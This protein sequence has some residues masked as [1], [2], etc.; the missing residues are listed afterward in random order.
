MDIDGYNGATLLVEVVIGA[1]AWMILDWAYEMLK[2]YLVAIAKWLYEKMPWLDFK[3][4]GKQFAEYC[5][6]HRLEHQTV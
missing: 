1:I 6:K 3:A 4:V 2:P 5:N